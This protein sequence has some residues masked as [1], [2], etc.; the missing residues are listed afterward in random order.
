VK[1]EIA[2][3]AVTGQDQTRVSEFTFN[4]LILNIK[5]ELI[6]V[7][8]IYHLYKVVVELLKILE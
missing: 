3:D 1:D 8:V 2:F 7:N 4:I 6:A 5:L